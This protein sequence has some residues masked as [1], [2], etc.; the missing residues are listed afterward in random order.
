[1]PQLC[2]GT[3]GEQRP[4]FL[5]FHGRGVTAGMDLA[6]AAQKGMIVG[7]PWMLV[8]P[9]V[10]VSLLLY[11]DIVLIYRYNDLFAGKTDTPFFCF[12]GD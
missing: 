4:L 3:A 9:I 8:K 12:G 6:L 2:G 7:W 11:W 1:M 5:H 10:C